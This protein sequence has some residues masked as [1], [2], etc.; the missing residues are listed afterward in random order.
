MTKIAEL[1]AIHMP[2][3]KHHTNIKL[4]SKFKLNIYHGVFTYSQKKRT[5]Q[6]FN[7]LDSIFIHIKSIF[8]IC[9]AFI[10]GQLREYFIIILKSLNFSTNFKARQPSILELKHDSFDLQITVTTCGYCFSNT[11]SVCNF[12]VNI[13]YQVDS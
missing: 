11:E 3:G 13:F 2:D 5:F 10:F 12:L 6:S 7:E 9:I 1:N 4:H 8:Q